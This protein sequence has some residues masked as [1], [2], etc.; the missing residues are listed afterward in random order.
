[1][2]P[3][4]ADLRRK[5]APLKRFIPGA[6]GPHLSS[7][8]NRPQVPEHGNLVTAE[9]VQRLTGRPIREGLRRELFEPWTL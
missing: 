6:I 9:L 3:D 4:N 7:S 5:H 2:L 8:G 1:M